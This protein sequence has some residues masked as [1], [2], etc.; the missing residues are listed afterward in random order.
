MTYY[1]PREHYK[2]TDFYHQCIL[3]KDIPKGTKTT[4][5]FLPEKFAVLEKVIKLKDNNGDWE[6]GWVVKF[7]RYD[8]D[9]VN[10]S[11]IAQDVHFRIPIRHQY[12]DGLDGLEGDDHMGPTARNLGRQAGGGGQPH[13]AHDRSAP[14]RR[15]KGFTDGDVKSFVG[16]H[17]SQH[18]G[19]HHISLAPDTGNNQI[20][21]IG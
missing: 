3:H 20:K 13:M 15:P 6:D 18:P 19:G 2:K 5:T 17:I 8:A 11:D 9:G 21:G 12:T 14:L 4:T 7:A 16:K 1:D 10:G